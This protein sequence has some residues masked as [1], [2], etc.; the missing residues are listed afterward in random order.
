L[1]RDT[2]HAA[3]IRKTWALKARYPNLQI[4]VFDAENKQSETIGLVAA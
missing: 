2:K 4:K 3:Q 1:A